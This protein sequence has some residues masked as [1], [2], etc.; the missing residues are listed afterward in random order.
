MIYRGDCKVTYKY[1]QKF[2]NVSKELFI[3]S[4]GS[5]FGEECLV[6]EKASQFTVESGKQGAEV[7]WISRSDFLKLPLTLQTRIKEQTHFRANNL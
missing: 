2:Q 6:G 4:E 5:F 3:L 7:L 1:C